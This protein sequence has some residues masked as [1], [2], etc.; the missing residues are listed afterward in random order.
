MA[1]MLWWSFPLMIFLILFYYPAAI[2]Y[3][4]NKL[5]NSFGEQWESW[6]KDIHALIPSF[7]KKA[8]SASSDWSF[9]QSLFQNLEPVIVL[10]L[11]WCIYML[12]AKL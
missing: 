8:G 7:S 2:S 12:Y 9:K 5:K 11:I 4:D 6:S 10:Y 1:S 3:E